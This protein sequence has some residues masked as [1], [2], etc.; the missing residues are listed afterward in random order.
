MFFL[1]N[2]ILLTFQGLKVLIAGLVKIRLVRT[3]LYLFSP[4]KNPK[5]LIQEGL[6]SVLVW[7]R[8]IDAFMMSSDCSWQPG[9][10]FQTQS[11]G[12]R[13]DKPLPKLHVC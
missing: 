7:C 10:S 12:H 13:L 2:T 3:E 1:K 4:L 8:T 6:N 11:L 5:A 9:A